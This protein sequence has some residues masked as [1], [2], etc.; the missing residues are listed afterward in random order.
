MR[1][2]RERIEFG[3]K[4][5]EEADRRLM[6]VDKEGSERLRKA[7]VF[8]LAI[9]KDSEEMGKKRFQEIVHGAEQK[10]DHLLKEAALLSKRREQEEKDHLMQEARGIIKEALIKTVELDPKHVDEKLIAYATSAI[11]TGGSANAVADEI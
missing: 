9:V 11:R 2:R 3:I 8:A 5:A 7:D 1:K 10:A 4:G 6:A